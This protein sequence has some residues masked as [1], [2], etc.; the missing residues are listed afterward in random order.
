MDQTTITQWLQDWAQGDRDARDR[1]I[2]AVYQQVRVIANN[3]LTPERSDHTL[4]ATALVNEAFE[5]I[6]RGNDIQWQDRQHFFAIAARAIR[7]VLTDSG[8]AR[9]AEKRSQGRNI[10]L[11]TDLASDASD[12]I[13][14]LALDQALNQLEKLNKTQASIVE[15]RYFAGLSIVETAAA[16]DLST[17]TVNRHWRAARAYLYAQLGRD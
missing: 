17:A 13:D 4:Q 6:F 5:K 8:R 1:V 10:T 16:T 2:E 15:L 9:M 3:Q 11:R 14:L 7:Q 12:P